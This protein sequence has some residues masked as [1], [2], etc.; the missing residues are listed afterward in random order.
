MCPSVE[1]T[2]NPKHSAITRELHLCDL[3]QTDNN[4]TGKSFKVV[5]N[6]IDKTVTSVKMPSCYY[7]P[8]INK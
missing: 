8:Y 3:T 7:V 4:V 6:V 2:T 1:I 5:K